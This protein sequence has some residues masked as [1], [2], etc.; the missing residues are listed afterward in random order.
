[1]RSSQT[2]RRD[3]MRYEMSSRLKCL[4]RDCAKRNEN[5]RILQFK[6]L[7]IEAIKA[8]AIGTDMRS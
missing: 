8:I 4:A 5:K 1:M 7:I 3:Y 2:Q 6:I